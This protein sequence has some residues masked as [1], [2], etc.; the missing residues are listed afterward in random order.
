MTRHKILLIDDHHLFSDG[1]KELLQKEEDL[2]VIGQVF[3]GADVLRQVHLRSPDL[4]LLDVNL[5]QV[6]G[7]DLAEIIL[8]DFAQTRVIILTM[9]AEKQVVDTFRKMHVHGYILKN[10]TRDTLLQG[11]R[12]VLRGETFFDPNVEAP[13]NI[14]PLLDDEFI[15]KFALTPREIEMVRLIKQ[16]LSSQE[17][18]DRL[19][20][21][22]LTIKTH[23]RNIHFK[24]GTETTA[25]L[26]RFANEY[27]I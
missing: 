19:S 9:Y 14:S 2:V 6:N 7:R 10:T 3:D 23:R 24:L 8:R 5:P 4:V 15:K 18:A 20:L 13:K 26:I 12:A 17:I 1:L 21:S 22:L 25:D 27:G 11:I 16:G